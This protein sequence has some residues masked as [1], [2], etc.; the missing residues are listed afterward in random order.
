MSRVLVVGGAGFLGS[1][2]ARRLLRRGDQVVIA[3][4]FEDSGDGREAREERGAGLRGEANAVVVR[5]DMADPL[6]AHSVITEHRPEVVV[7][8]ARF[9]AAG[10][11]VEA[12]VE[13]C[14]SVRVDHFLHLS[15]S[16]LYGP[17]PDLRRASEDEPLV[18]AGDPR[19][20]A[21]ARDEALITN[22]ALPFVILRLF[23]PIGPAM[24]MSRFPMQELEAVLAD[25]EVFLSDTMPRDFLH[26]ADAARAIELAIE[27]RPLAAVLNV[28][29]GT[30]VAPRALVERLGRRAG[31]VPRIVCLPPQRSWRIADMERIW[32]TLGFAP[33]RDLDRLASDIVS[34]RL[35]GAPANFAPARPS[36]VDES[37]A[38]GPPLTVSRRELFD[39]FR[40]R[41]GKGPGAK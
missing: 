6:V 5:A 35:A 40:G 2:L 25:E 31:K 20:E 27:K 11:G 17:A 8:A 3:D 19:R 41:F 7:N 1:A 15:D 24:P 10:P 16:D 30:P 37:Q 38:P 18:T 9:S 23:E 28:G 34:A 22:S 36:H 29:S 32:S 14:L 39:V 21:S 4:S 13:S 26:V 12:L 33:E